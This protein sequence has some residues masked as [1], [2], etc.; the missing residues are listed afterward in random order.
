[1]MYRGIRSCL[2][3]RGRWVGSISF[4]LCGI[5]VAVAELIGGEPTGQVIFAVALFGGVAVLLAVGGRSESIRVFRGEL[6]DERL[7]TIQ[8][9]AQ[10]LAGQAVLVAVVVAFTV[11]LALGHSGAPYDWLGAIG[12]LTYLGA[13][14]YGTRR[15]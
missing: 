14:S 13:Y 15:S 9:R 12:G 2:S 11:D 6:R 5:V 10:A 8:L 7:D 1:M 4:A 3:G